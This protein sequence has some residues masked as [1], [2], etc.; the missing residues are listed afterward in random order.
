[1]K[2]KEPFMTSTPKI[3][4]LNKDAHAALKINN[5]NAFGHIANEHLIPVTAHEYVFAGAEYP[6]VF[7][8]NEEKD[9]YQSVVMLGLV[10]NQNLFMQEGTWQGNY[11]PAAA[12]NYPLALVKE[13][14]ESDR[15]LVAVDEN[16]SRVSNDTGEALFNEDGTETEF[17]TQRKQH[18]AEFLELGQVTIKMINKLH[19]LDL[20]K[21][22]VLT[23]K[24]DGE[25]RRINGIYL[26]D[27]EKLANLDDATLLELHK[28][29][30][31]KVIYAHL[32]SLQHTQKLVKKASKAS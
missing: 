29:G 26:V 6:I 32:L 23:L 12:R 27:E 31:L 2:V 7:I 3:M 28:N 5:D 22:Q 4:P 16:S 20:F 17:L 24:V 10:A 21:Q 25:E 18:M 13:S 14:P 9:I 19:S 15:L 11:M 30:Y 1:M 8:K